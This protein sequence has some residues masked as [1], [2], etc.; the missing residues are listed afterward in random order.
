MRV[1]SFHGVDVA[2]VP[3]SI[4]KLIHLRYLDISGTKIQAFA[5]S[6]CML[7]N[8]QTL[9]LN[10][11]DFLE[12]IPSQLSK[13]KNLR[14][15]HY[16]SFDATCL[17]PFNMGQLT[18][19]QTLQLFNVGYDGGQQIGEI[20]FLK[21]LGGELEIRNLEKVNNQQICVERKIFIS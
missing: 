20:G 7:F 9:I 14:H 3:S 12:R 8:L 13:L 2:E 18:C 19:L 4:N 1:L 10:G 21:E 17:M 16:Y 6:L 15:L 5:D 11:C